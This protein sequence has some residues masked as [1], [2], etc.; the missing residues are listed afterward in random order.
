MAYQNHPYHPEE[1]AELGAPVALKRES[2]GARHQQ[3]AAS[4]SAGHADTKLT[5]QEAERER[6]QAEK[7]AWR[8]ANEYVR[9]TA[10]AGGG[11]LTGVATTA[12]S[13]VLVAIVAE[14]N[15]R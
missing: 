1:L 3:S 4:S 2:A 5:K 15:W 9:A 8:I 14:E 7:R 10:G 6:Q 12:T 11:A 13:D